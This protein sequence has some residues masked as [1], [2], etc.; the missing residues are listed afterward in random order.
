MAIDRT[1][2]FGEDHLTA[3]I[4]LGMAHG[5]IKGILTDECLKNVKN[6][7]MTYFGGVM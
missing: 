3:S 4:A 5:T 1:F 2:Q 6:A 7:H